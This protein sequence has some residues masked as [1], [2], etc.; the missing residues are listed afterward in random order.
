MTE[1]L[2]KLDRRE[3][4]RFARFVDVLAEDLDAELTADELA[5]RLHLSRFHFDR[6]IAAIAG[7]SPTKF[8]RR[9]LMERA[10]YWMVT[11]HRSLLRI[12][13]D[14]G[15]SS[16]EAFTR[17]FIRAYGVAP[18]AWRERPT[19]YQLPADTDVHFHPPGGLRLP[20]R[21]RM[22]AMQVLQEMVQH[23]VW[24]VDAMVGR[25]QRLDD[26]DLDEPLTTRL[27][28]LDGA[29]L[30]WVLS[31]LIGQLEMWLAAM[32]DAE[33]DFAVERD[34][35]VASMARRITRSGPEFVEQVSSLA[36]EGRF[37]ETFVD[38]FKEPPMVM[39]YAAMVAHVLT[40]AAHHRLL[41]LTRFAELGIDDL[42]FGDPKD[43]FNPKNP[44][45]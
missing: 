37:D 40:F 34:E 5:A 3:A 2:D 23:H 29:S 15:F 8:R 39:T 6:V 42:G 21:Q 43:W 31:R 44:Q 45:G 30:R 35:P 36:R 38:A 16:H 13:T 26:A 14:S 17:A 41:A 7:E 27:E 18:S 19:K 12:A 32:R 1:G 20:A 4:D 28:G 9:V 24:L 11:T 25:A 33:Y 22:D 10:A